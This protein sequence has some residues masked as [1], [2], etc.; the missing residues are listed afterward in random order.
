M[1]P[2]D[3]NTLVQ[4]VATIAG[5]LQQLG[6][7]GLVALV[8]AAPAAVLITVLVLNHLQDRKTAAMLEVY[9]QDMAKLT[10]IARAEAETARAEALTQLEV[11]RAD[12]QS[13]LRSLGKEHSETAQYYKDN[14]ELVKSYERMAKDLSDLVASN[15]RLLERLAGQISNNMYCPLVRERAHGSK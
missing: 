6:V 2:A 4:A 1:N 9:R 11:Y 14:V 3:L 8:L 12:T 5:V 10:E 7:P 15:V 13:I